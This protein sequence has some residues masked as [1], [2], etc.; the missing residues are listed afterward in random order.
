MGFSGSNLFGNEI[1][2][3]KCL[4]FADK[5]RTSR[6]FSVNRISNIK[7]S[8]KNISIRLL[9][10]RLKVTNIETA[11]GR[12]D[13]LQLFRKKSSQRREIGLQVQ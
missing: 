8:S 10:L 11:T 2:F 13:F 7:T 5:S 9:K 6:L 12:N 4:V 3:Q 1:T